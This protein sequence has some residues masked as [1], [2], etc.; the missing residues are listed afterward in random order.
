[1]AAM[2]PDALSWLWMAGA[3]LAVLL[4]MQVV[5]RLAR[6]HLGGAATGSRRIAVVE[7]APLD[8]RRR[9]VLLRVDGREALILTGGASDVVVGWL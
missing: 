1:M 6:R 5:G 7:V 4:L 2:G 9:A 3:L 8:S